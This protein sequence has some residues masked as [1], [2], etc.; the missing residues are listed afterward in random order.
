MTEQQT[1][2]QHNTDTAMRS[3]DLQL[4]AEGEGSGADGATAGQ[5][6]EG[7]QSAA[8]TGGESAASAT[9]Q[10][11]NDL[12]T[13]QTGQEQQAQGDGEQGGQQ[14][15]APEAYKDFTVPEGFTYDKDSATKFGAIAKELNLS[16][17]QAQKLV[18]FYGGQMQAIDATRQGTVE[19]WYNDSIKQYKPEEIALANRTLGRFADQEFIGLLAETGL[20]NHPKVIGLF[21]SIGGLIAEGKFIDTQAAPDGGNKPLYGNSPGMYK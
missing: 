13:G 19:G 2:V 6:A 11:K 12:L 20:S 7:G 17:E 3:F 10:Q 15:G 4:F 9:G 14:P 21:K 18:D 8:A 16:Q 1:A 5:G